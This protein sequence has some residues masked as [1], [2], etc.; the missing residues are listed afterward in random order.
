MIGLPVTWLN[1]NVN[2]L[3]LIASKN[4][5]IQNDPGIKKTVKRKQTKNEKAEVEESQNNDNEEDGDGDVMEI[6]ESKLVVD[7]AMIDEEFEANAAAEDDDDEF[8]SI[9]KSTVITSASA[10]KRVTR[11][12]T[13]K[14]RLSLDLEDDEFSNMA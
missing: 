9:S 8:V 13:K 7:E 5:Q 11:S 3:H 14:N 4:R 10:S 12:S 6:E 2:H 1:L